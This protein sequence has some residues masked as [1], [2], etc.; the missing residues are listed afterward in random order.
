MFVHGAQQGQFVAFAVDF[1]PPLS[2]R[3][4]ACNGIERD[5]VVIV[6]DHQLVDGIVEGVA[7]RVALEH[8]SGVAP[9]DQ[10]GLGQWL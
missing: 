10:A 4:E 7:L 5:A 6:G 1:D 9:Q 8:V 2:I 3:R